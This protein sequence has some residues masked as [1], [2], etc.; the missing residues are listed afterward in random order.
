M[1]A[2]DRSHWPSIVL[3]VSLCAFAAFLQF[4]LPPI[5][6]DFLQLYDHNASVAAGFMSIFA[7]VGLAVSTP[8]GRFL[9]K[10]GIVLGLALGFGLAMSGIGLGLLLPQSSPA[11]LA[12]RGL[13]GLAFAALALIGPAIANRAAARRDLALVTG[14][15]ATWIPIGQILGALLVLAGLDWRGLWIVNLLLVP[16]LVFAC[17]RLRD[18]IFDRI[19]PT[20]PAS[21]SPISIG[22]NRLV[23]ASSIF[24]LW[25]L[26][27]FAFMTWLTQYLR[28]ELSLSRQASVLAYLLP[29]A[30]VLVCNVATGLALRHGMKLLPALIAALSMQF[31][32]WAAS[33]WLQGEIGLIALILYGIGAGITPACLFHLPHFIAGTKAGP[34]AFGVLLTGRNIGVFLGP[35]LMAQL[36]QGSLGWLGGALAMAGLVAVA[37]LLAVLLGL[38]L[39]QGTSR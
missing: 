13:E 21:V 1:S 39:R 3:G 9:E 16:V 23:L 6:P 31:A 19:A 15:I 4:K 35:I 10:R 26:Q 33:P 24:L 20:A 25:S 12:A 14:L 30:V 27:Y 32:V 29:A 7:L 18:H 28:E 22:S 8:L 17:W 38:R 11:M 34:R 2:Q 37:C 36:F 5:L